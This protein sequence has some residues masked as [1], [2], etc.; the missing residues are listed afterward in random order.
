MLNHGRIQSIANKTQNNTV[1][2]AKYATAFTWRFVDDGEQQ[3]AAIK[4]RARQLVA[5]IKDEKVSVLACKMCSVNANRKGE[6]GVHVAI[7]M[8]QKWIEEQRQQG[9]KVELIDIFCDALKFCADN[10]ASLQKLCL[11]DLQQAVL[12]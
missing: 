12:R 3:D 9:C 1:D 8:H 5:A 7:G 4:G 2:I 6:N 11:R 10:N